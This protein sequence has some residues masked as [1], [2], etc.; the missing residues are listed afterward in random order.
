MRFVICHTC[1]HVVQVGG[2]LEEIQNLLGSTENYPCI[3]AL[4]QGRMQAVAPARIPAGYQLQE[5]PIR[6]FF[7]AIHG[8]GPGNGDPASL[9]RFR[10]LMLSQRV[11][12]V[13][14]EPI[15]QPER[16]IIREL[17][18]ESGIRLHFE[19]SAKGACVYYIEEP[20]PSCVEVVEHELAAAASEGGD[21]NRE[22]AGRAPQAGPDRGQTAKGPDDHSRASEL[23]NS[24]CVSSMPETGGVRIGVVSGCAP[25]GTDPNVR[26]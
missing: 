6:G 8:F 3:T 2:N 14:A 24:E 22:E 20:G 7:R 16:V 13:V 21:S 25:T 26:V 19:T 4:C 1:K 10:E 12:D 9:K 15:G 5:V 23:P 18:L 11:V 17:V